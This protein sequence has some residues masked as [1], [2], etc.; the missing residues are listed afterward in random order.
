MRV[1]TDDPPEKLPPDLK[2]RGLAFDYF[3]GKAWKR[4]NPARH[5]I[6]TQ[7]RFYK[8][9]NSAQD[10]DLMR[11]TFFVEALSTDVVFAASRTLAVSRDIGIL[12]QDTANNLYTSLHAQNKTRYFAISDPIRPNPANITDWRIVPPEIT[13]TYL[14]LPQLDP[15]I[16]DLAKSASQNA[17]NQYAKA[18][19]LEKYLRTHYTYSLTLRGDPNHKDP[20]A[21]F[22]FEVRAGHC[23]YF[24]SA[25]TIMLRQIGIPARMVNG[26]SA[27]EYNRIGN[28]WTVRKYHAHSWVEAYFPPYGWIEFDPTPTSPASPRS[29]SA[30]FFSNITDAIGLWWWEGVVNYDSSQQYHIVNGLLSGLEKIQNNASAL[31]DFIKQQG[32]NA[33]AALHAPIEI[34]EPN[35]KLFLWMPLFVILTSLLIR[36]IRRRLFHRVMHFKHRKNSRAAAISFY[37]EALDL[38]EVYGLHRHKDQTPLEFAQSLSPHPAASFFLSLTHIYNAARFGEMDESFT[39]SETQTLLSSLR[40]SLKSNPQP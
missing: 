2:W 30:Q 33:V 22:L 17:T 21:M 23:E 25:M 39:P 11:Q 38:L 37:A 4:S 8:L 14:Q 18:R 34:P 12:E 3:D 36:P 20:L 5:P 32:R 7:G 6:P 15:R 1:K 31:I 24:A 19:T 16:N 10:S 28:N 29:S 26:F 35:K 9:E 13:A 40:K 27:G